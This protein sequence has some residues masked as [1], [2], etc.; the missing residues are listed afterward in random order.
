MPKK[1]STKKNSR[2]S[3]KRRVA[4]KTQPVKPVV[5]KTSPRQVMVIVHGGGDIPQDYCKGLVE[6]IEAQLVRPFDY[7]AAYYSDVITQHARG[8]VALAE[9]PEEKNFKAEYE[10]LLRETHERN[11]EDQRKRGI[12]PMGF[13]GIDPALADTINEVAQYIFNASAAAEVQQ[14]LVET[15]NQATQ[16]FDTIVLVTHS[17]GTIVA[18]DVLK[19]FANRYKISS[20]FTL[21]C[22]LGKLVKTRV[23]EAGLGVISPLTIP[24][25]YN[26]YD[27][28]DFVADVIGSFFHAPDF[29]VYDI[30]VEVAPSMPAAHDYFLNA[31]TH[32]LLANAIR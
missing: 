22:P 9:S 24:Q 10:K 11:Q 29:H 20:W 8:V 1:K 21:G 30:F 15:L 12:A 6:G 18:Y 2:A 32:A 25:W 3:R 17:L 16:D 14:R 7:V 31:E 13:L 19:Q 4:P 26:L 28:N 23:R 27:T 5:K